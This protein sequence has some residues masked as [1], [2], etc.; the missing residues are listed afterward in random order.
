[1]IAW[2]A[3]LERW[4]TLEPQLGLLATAGSDTVSADTSSTS[5]RKIYSTAHKLTVASSGSASV[6]FAMDTDYL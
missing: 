1:M 5:T 6:N 4:Q 3:K 2:S